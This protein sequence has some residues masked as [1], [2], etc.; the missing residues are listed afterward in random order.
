MVEIIT[1]KYLDMLIY[2]AG[3]NE[4]RAGRDADSVADKLLMLKKP[5]LENQDKAE[6]GDLVIKAKRSGDIGDAYDVHEKLDQIL[7]GSKE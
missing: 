7:R 6:L 3:L 4:M 5:I 2:Q 1:E